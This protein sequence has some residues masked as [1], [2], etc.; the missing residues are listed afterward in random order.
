MDEIPQETP[1]RRHLGRRIARI[2]LASYVGVTLVLMLL[3]TTMV[4]PVRTA[5]QGDWVA[6]F[7]PHEEVD[8]TS[9]D[10]TKL[11]GWLFEHP[12]PKQVIL[13]CHGNAEHVADNA[14]LMDYLRDE[15]E[16]TVFVFDYRGYGKSE[17]SPHEAGVVA[18]GLAA[19]EWLANRTGVATDQIV[20]FGRSLG[21]GVAVA[22]AAEQGAKALV[23]QSTFGRMVDVAASKY[24][25]VPVRLVMR[26]RYDSIGRIA[27]YKGPLLQ[28]HGKA[29]EL[30]PYEQARQL[31][32]AAP[33]T[34]KE[35]FEL[36]GDHL[37]PQSSGYY[38]K[39]KQFLGSLD[40]PAE[41][42]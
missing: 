25:W 24:P 29:D 34:Q 33:T 26:N 6:S 17:G 18:D 10:G 27:N 21:G 2:V 1:K 7:Y 11:H 37:T 14:D 8:F 9:G 41:D 40:A 12:S 13:Y 38:V 30:I 3:E 4:Y 42:Q 19:Q 32:E 22:A 15:L 36:P 23:L 16:A 39:L 28:S 31:F 35:W 20:I 5:D